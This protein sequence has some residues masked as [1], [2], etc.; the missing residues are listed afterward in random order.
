MMKGS[1]LKQKKS[2]LG[3]MGAVWPRKRKSDETLELKQCQTEPEDLRPAKETN[4]EHKKWRS[5]TRPAHG[6][7][8]RL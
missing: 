3:G 1:A 2:R 6:S 5:P 8:K 7:A 4:A